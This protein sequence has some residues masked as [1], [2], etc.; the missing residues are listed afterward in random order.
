MKPIRFFRHV[1][2]EPPGYFGTFLE[3]HGYAYEVTCLDEGIAVPRDLDE[4]AGLV[5][6]GGPGNVNEPTGWMA[7]EL[8]LIRDAA[9][10]GLPML[11]ICLGAQL[12]SKALG[13]SLTSTPIDWRLLCCWRSATPSSSSKATSRRTIPGSVSGSRECSKATSTVLPPSI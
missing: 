11:G 2:C 6:M 13:G 9:D 5:F 10:R 4:V 12:I 3:E 8:D 1:A 7:Q